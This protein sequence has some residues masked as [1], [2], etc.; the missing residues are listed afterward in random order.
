MEDRQVVTIKYSAVRVSD[1]VETLGG[2]LRL[3]D[4]KLSD[5]Q[6]VEKALVQFQ[7]S[8]QK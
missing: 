2:E 6:K 5:I 4:M 1:G 8:L 3:G 7:M